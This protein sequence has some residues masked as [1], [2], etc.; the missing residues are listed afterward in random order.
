MLR[1]R[2]LLFAIAFLFTLNTFAQPPGLI[3]D[4]VAAVI[5][6]KENRSKELFGFIGVVFLCFAMGE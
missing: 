3:I 4:Q 1:N 2:I 6:G 5:G